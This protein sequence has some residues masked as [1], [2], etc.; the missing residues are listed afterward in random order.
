MREQANASLQ[1]GNACERT[2]RAQNLRPGST[3]FSTVFGNAKKNT[4]KPNLK[5]LQ[6]MQLTIQKPP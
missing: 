5:R 3:F 6:G 4:S 2:Y 1:P